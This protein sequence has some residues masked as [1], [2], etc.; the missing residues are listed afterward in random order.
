MS[1]VRPRIFKHDDIAKG[2]NEYVDQT[3]L[4]ILEE[5]YN[6]LM[7]KDTFFRLVRESEEGKEG[8]S[9]ALSDSKKRADAKA[10]SYLV[11]NALHNKVNP[12]FTMFMLKQARFGWKDKQEIELSGLEFNVTR[13]NSDTE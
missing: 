8:I 5:F 4:P 12:V 3:D 7:S 10:E 11:K 1:L 13:V 9:P 6:K 2:L